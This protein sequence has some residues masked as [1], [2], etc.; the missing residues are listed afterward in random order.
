M[1]ARIKQINITDI[2]CYSLVTGI[3]VKERKREEE[4]ERDTICDALH[5]PA[6]GVILF[7]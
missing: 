3:K 1:S 4:K 2:K 7:H 6:S 5:I